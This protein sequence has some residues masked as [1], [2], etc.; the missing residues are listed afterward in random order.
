M[1][2]RRWRHGPPSLVGLDILQPEQT[3]LGAIFRAVEEEATYVARGHYEILTEVCGA[4]PDEHP[5]RRRSGAGQALAADPG[6][7]ARRAGRDAACAGGDLVR[8][9]ALRA[10]RRRGLR[11]SAGGGRGH[12]PGAGPVRAGRGQP[13]RLRRGVR[14]LAGAERPPPR[15]GRSAA[16][17]RSS[18]RA[19][20]HERAAGGRRRMSRDQTAAP[21][22]PGD[23]ELE[24]L[25]A[26][27]RLIGADPDAR[28]ARRR[29][30]LEQDRGDRPP[31]PR[32]DGAAHQ[33]QRHRPEDDRRRTGFPGSSWTSCCRCASATAMSDEEM[34]DYL[35]HCMVE[36]GSRRPSIETLLHAFL[37]A[38]HVDHVHADAICA[39]TNTPDAE[40]HVREAL[41]PDVAIVPYIRPGFDLSRQ[42]GE[43][44]G[45]SAVVLDK[46]GLVTWGETP[47]GIV[48]PH[49]GAGGPRRGLP[50]RARTT[51]ARAASP[52][53]TPPTTEA[54]L[55]DPARPA[56][57]RWA[58]R[59]ARRSRAA[60]PGRSARRRS[61][62]H[63]GA[64]HAG[65]RAAH[66]RAVARR[67]RSGGGRGRGGRLRGGATAPTSR[68]I[69]IV[70]RPGWRCCRP[71]RGSS[72]CRVS[73]ASPPARMR[74]RR[75]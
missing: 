34:V 21:R 74:G 62:G 52:I 27:S 22:I 44:A 75:E 54:L 40:R 17:C 23:T 69:G 38:R 39:L 3:G 33:G 67:A 50:G 20:A 56:L 61:G 16:S 4:A 60:R 25:V 1:E 8:R 35:A 73:A 13:R 41:G 58:A 72:S 2:G 37:P 29:Q 5:L 42:V 59:P 7:C 55:L 15:G 57:P 66:R 18:G 10:R 49:P 46:H 47:R 19:R 11:R 51:P 64:R 43:L 53:S 36:P 48:R 14:A 6:R 12:Q 70:C 32:A 63:G 71:C 45:A 26:R 28:R 31:R 65:P 24:R 9:G 30:H 68:A